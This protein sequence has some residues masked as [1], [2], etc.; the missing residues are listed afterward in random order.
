M[1][2]L[3]RCS[4]QYLPTARDSNGIVTTRDTAG[5]KVWAAALW[6][7]PV[8]YELKEGFN[9]GKNWAVCVVPD[10]Y[11]MPAAVATAIAS[12]PDIIPVNYPRAQVLDTAARN[13]IA[14]KLG[15]TDLGAITLAANDTVDDLADRIVKGVLGHSTAF[16]AREVGKAAVAQGVV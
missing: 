9:R 3:S 15:L 5:R 13:A 10:D 14:N 16:V 7:Y 8:P 11:V 2:I 6:K 4:L 12:D 1:F